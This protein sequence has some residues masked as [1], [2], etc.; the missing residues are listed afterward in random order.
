MAVAL[1]IRSEYWEG[2]SWTTT[3]L[4]VSVADST[5]LQQ[6]EVSSIACTVYDVNDLSTN[7]YTGAAPVVASVVFDTLQTNYGWSYGDGY[8]FRHAIDPTSSITG[9]QGGHGYKIE[10][11]FTTA[12]EGKYAVVHWVTVRPMG[13]V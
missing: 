2:E 10:Y 3:A 9:Y 8:N 1:D 11:V 12:S 7:V 13:G 6:V 5:A 4:V